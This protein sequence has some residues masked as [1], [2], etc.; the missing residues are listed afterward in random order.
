[1]PSIELVCA[2]QSEPL[3]FSN[4][5]FAL[6]T[7]RHPASHRPR[8]LFQRELSRLRGCMYH[9]GNP[10]CADPA[11]QGAFFAFDVLSSDSRERQRRRF[12]EIAP[13]FREGFCSLLRRLLEASPTHT[14][15]LYTDWQFGPA[16]TT[17]GGL[18]SE[19]AFWHRHDTRQLRLN[20][21]Y[22]IYP[23]AAEDAA[24]NFRSPL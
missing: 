3:E 1:M 9:I 21:C 18:I 15:F 10:Q 14:V 19:S 5:P 4:L 13:E 8:P 6:A 23:D 12:F 11:Y 16:Q 17:R 7:D 20:A 2:E 22:M 24:G